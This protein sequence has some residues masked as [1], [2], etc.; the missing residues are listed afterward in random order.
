[1]TVWNMLLLGLSAGILIPMA[2]WS[3]ECAV[4]LLPPRRMDWYTRARRPRIAVL[5]PAH[6]EADVIRKTLKGLASQILP[7]DR[8]IVIADNCNDNTAGI[9]R[10]SGGIIVERHDSVHQGKSY[11]LDYGVESLAA[12]PPEVFIFVDADCHA[13]PGA[14]DHMARLAY[15]TGRPVQANFSFESRLQATS[16]DQLA[17]LACLVKN[18]VRP[19]GLDRFG[20]PCFLN[21]SGMAFPAGILRNSILANGRIAEDKWL[22]VELALQRHVPVFCREAKITSRLATQKYAKATQTTRWLHGHLE[23]M[24][25]Q[26]PRLLAGA[27]RQ[28]RIDL[29]GLLLDLSVPPLSLLLMLWIPALAATA[30][31]GILGRGWIP[32]IPTAAGGL[33]MAA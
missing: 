17:E 19:S 27:I 12:D 16:W 28:R 33:F 9:A 3:L 31:A 29:L 21:G 20:L 11:A 25:L 23:C 14:I 5:V 22:T 24:L 10:G 15:A 32:V 13:L 4:A 2:V 8:L 1:M 18:F 30:I 26:G 7:G 6:N